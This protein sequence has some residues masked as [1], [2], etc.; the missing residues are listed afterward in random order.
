[1]TT[2][3]TSPAPAGAKTSGL[4]IAS[5]V[6]G[7]AGLCTAGLG[8]VVGL[9]LGLMALKKIGDSGGRV[10]GRGLAIAGLAVS[11]VTV[12]LWIAA[13]AVGALFFTL[14]EPPPPRPVPIRQSLA[15]HFDKD[16]TEK[17]AEQKAGFWKG[18]GPNGRFEHEPL[19]DKKVE[20][21]LGADDYVNLPIQ[22]ADG[23]Y[24]GVVFVT[25]NAN[26]MSQIPH[27]PKVCMQQS[28][29][30][31]IGERLFDPKEVYWK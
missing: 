20:S 26:A 14:W 12:L 1:M 25:Y 16:L 18:T 30:E 19:K 13:I 6:C 2:T 31:V 15:A 9:S 29:F 17:M 10:G 21:A 5:L 7:I 28:G 4:A 27:Y 23:R 8:S 22:S 24:T 3:T 11:V